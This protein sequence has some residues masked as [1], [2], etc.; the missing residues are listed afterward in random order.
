MTT[1]RSGE[2]STSS[3]LEAREPERLRSLCWEL[4]TRFPP[5]LGGD[6]LALAV[7]HQHLGFLHWQLRS[8]SVER[9]KV[10]KGQSFDGARLAL[11][12]YDVTD[13][14][15]DG[16]NAHGF[17]D[18]GVEGLSG[19]HYFHIGQ[20][21]RNLLAE[22]GFALPSGEYCALARSR[23]CLFD[24]D[25]P[26][27]RFSLRGLYVA[28]GYRRVF[29][30][31]NVLD[32]PVYERLARDLSQVERQTPI[33]VA[34]LHIGFGGRLQQLLDRFG[35]RAPA[36]SLAAERFGRR[37][38]DP[39][40]D[41]SALV[42]WAESQAEALATEIVEAHAESHFELLH[43][44]DWSAIPAALEACERLDLPLVLSL[45]STEIDRAGGALGET[46]IREWERRGIEAAELSLVPH[47]YLRQQL[48]NRCE[49][50]DERVLIVPD[51]YEEPQ[52]SLPDPGEQKSSL[53]LHPAWPV[54]LF[55]GE[56]SHAAGADL[57][58]DAL[59]SVCREHDRAQFVFAGEGPLRGE[60]EGRVHGAG[61]ANRCRFLGD[62]GG[63]AFDQILLASDFV[64][65]PAR[66]WQDEGLAQLATS[67]GKPV[68]TTHQAQVHCIVHGENGLVTYDNPGSIVWGVKELLQNP[69]QGN[70]LRSVAKQKAQHTQS[71]ESSVA[72]HY[73][74]YA[75]ALARWEEQ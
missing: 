3:E 60:L 74:A 8:S 5:Q 46:R 21:E 65:I 23:T 29:P 13:I 6:R 52:L 35:E 68:L 17:F 31:E 50:D 47:S 54:V 26:A 15:F 75:R 59:I 62:V 61:L 56:I 71:L 49:A 73:L 27:G 39:P 66:T 28:N 53:G 37:D 1:T 64:C 63:D 32:A 34:L 43:C 55:A 11:R 38:V 42:D 48:V 58:V 9:L 18:I 2:T 30:V 16:L 72:E 36:L 70:M 7:V 25:R 40:G 51:V 69:L 24:R 67:C 19:T 14:E 10:D 22:V 12:V 57:L 4:G 20:L 41:A 33:H 44:H 45:H